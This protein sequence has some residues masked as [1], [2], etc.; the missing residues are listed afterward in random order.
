[1]MDVFKGRITSSGFQSGDRI[2]VGSWNESIFG[3]FT[4]I[5]WAKPDG[6]RTLIAPNQKIA[7]YVDSMYT[8]DEIIIQEIQTRFLNLFQQ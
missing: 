4:D 1:M 3:Q 6:H 7:D 2:V 5:M 8:F